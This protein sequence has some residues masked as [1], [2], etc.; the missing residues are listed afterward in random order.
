MRA[1]EE[2]RNHTRTV[3]GQKVTP[4]L[5]W[6]VIYYSNYPLKPQSLRSKTE[7]K[8]PT[9]SQ[10]PASQAFHTRRTQPLSFIK[11]SFVRTPR[12]TTTTTRETTLQ[13]PRA[14]YGAHEKKL[15]IPARAANREKH[16]VLQAAAE[17]LA[18]PQSA[19]R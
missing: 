14:A 1:E 12:R 17:R 16:L 19:K 8:P 5:P 7:Q 3:K 10:I 13:T 2:Y 11:I 18:S 6:Y 4:F 15:G 9:T